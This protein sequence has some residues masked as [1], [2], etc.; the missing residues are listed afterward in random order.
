MNLFPQIDFALVRERRVSLRHTGPSPRSRR[1][2]RAAEDKY[3]EK[4]KKFF[5]LQVFLKTSKD[6]ASTAA[7]FES[8]FVK[9]RPAGLGALRP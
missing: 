4:G 6:V 9:S 3:Q 1:T 7:P 5:N 2:P 8:C